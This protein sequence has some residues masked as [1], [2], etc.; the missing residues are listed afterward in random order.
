MSE[1]M[2]D[3][4]KNFKT[5]V[6]YIFNL[7][8]QNVSDFHVTVYHD[9]HEEPEPEKH[10]STVSLYGGKT[11]VKI[12]QNYELLATGEANCSKNDVYS[13]WR[14]RNRAFSRAF[15]ELKSVKGWNCKNKTVQL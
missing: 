15:N 11:T 9:R 4:F 1:K 14:G 5:F 7:Y 8:E 12:Y 2:G 10:G 6:N 13:K 3:Q